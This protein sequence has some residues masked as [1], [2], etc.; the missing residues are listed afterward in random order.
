MTTAR[1]AAFQLC[2]DVRLV[3]TILSVPRVPK[4]LE[5]VSKIWIRGVEW[6]S[7]ISLTWTEYRFLSFYNRLYSER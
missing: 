7:Q 3:Q 4:R 5:Y 2:L 1:R 6:R